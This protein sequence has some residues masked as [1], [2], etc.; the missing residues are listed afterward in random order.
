MADTKLKNAPAAN[1]KL[2]PLHKQIALGKKPT[3]PV[4]TNIKKK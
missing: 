3:K 2:M 1:K 4:I